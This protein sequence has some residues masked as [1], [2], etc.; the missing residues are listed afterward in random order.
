MFPKCAL[1][2]NNYKYNFLATVIHKVAKLFS[3]YVIKIDVMQFRP[4]FQKKKKR[5][6]FKSEICTLIPLRRN[7]K[8]TPS[9]RKKK[10]GNEYR[11]VSRGI[12]RIPSRLHE[13]QLCITLHVRKYTHC[14]VSSVSPSVTV[15]RRGGKT[16][17]FRLSDC[18]A[19]RRAKLN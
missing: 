15:C 13:R 9:S 8:I 18:E 12:C 19:L 3:A 6:R 11:N 5:H 10:M 14:N 1:K 7:L 2:N 17:P 16:P 4:K